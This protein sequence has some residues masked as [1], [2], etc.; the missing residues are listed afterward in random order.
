MTLVDVEVVHFLNTCY[1]AGTEIA[2]GS[3]YIR[4][5][6][7]REGDTKHK[8]RGKCGLRK[9]NRLSEHIRT[10]F[11]TRTRRESV[12]RDQDPQLGEAGRKAGKSTYAR[13]KMFWWR[14]GLC[15]QIRST[16]KWALPRQHLFPVSEGGAR[17]PIGYNQCVRSCLGSS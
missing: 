10:G 3:P 7:L 6:M 16:T 15:V 13:D 11:S 5:W 14:K 2:H 8:L 9:P 1:D 12:S 4:E 17:A